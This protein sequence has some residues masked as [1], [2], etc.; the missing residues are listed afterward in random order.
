MKVFEEFKLLQNEV[1]T[2]TV[3]LCYNLM[4][5]SKDRCYTRISNKLN[6]YHLSPKVYWSTF[7]MFL[8]NKKT[9]IENTFVTDL[10]NKKTLIENTF[11]TDL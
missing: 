4:N 5:D 3:E 7:K 10:N 9:L 8:N 1:V 6:D 2:F 11:V